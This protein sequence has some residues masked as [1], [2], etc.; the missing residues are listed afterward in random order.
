[1]KDLMNQVE[2][3]DLRNNTTTTI[4]MSLLED[5][6]CRC[7]CVGKIVEDR[8]ELNANEATQLFKGQK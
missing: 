2:T 3:R 6:I 7:R 8:G 5:V 1:M 4:C